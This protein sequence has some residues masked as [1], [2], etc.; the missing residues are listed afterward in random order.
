[1]EVESQQCDRDREDAVTEGLNSALSHVTV[2][3]VAGCLW[4]EPTA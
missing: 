1:M 2:L 4:L 3:P